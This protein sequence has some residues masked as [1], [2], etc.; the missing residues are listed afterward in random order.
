MNG[1]LRLGIAPAEPAA[2]T[3]RAAGDRRLTAADGSAICAGHGDCVLFFG[4]LAFI[5]NSWLW[6]RVR[7]RRVFRSARSVGV[8]RLPIADASAIRGRARRS[9][10]PW[11]ARVL[12]QKRFS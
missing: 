11:H 2:V 3:R 5:G 1:V 10:S 4:S 8:G 9:E 12:F 6:I 7:A